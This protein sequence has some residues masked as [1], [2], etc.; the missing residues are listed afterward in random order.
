MEKV[1]YLRAN[2]SQN[3][4]SAALSYTTSFGTNFKLCQVLLKASTNITET[5][6]VTLDN[7]TGSNY[8]VVLDSTS[9]SAA[10][11]YVFR[12][13][14]DCIFMDGDEVKVACTNAGATGIVYVT[15][16]AEP[17]GQQK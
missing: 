17:Y 14:G 12:P 3:L 8:D 13:S 2:T 7:G 16:I 5:V 15:I 11:N 4:A 9:L 10:Q 6:T 1:Q